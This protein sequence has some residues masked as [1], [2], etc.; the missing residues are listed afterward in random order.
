MKNHEG[1][2]EGAGEEARPWFETYFGSDYLRT[3]RRQLTASTVEEVDFLVDRLGIGKDDRLLDIPCGH[4]RHA[5]ELVRRGYSV[6]GVDLS[7]DLLQ[8]ARKQAASQ[9]LTV[10]F[11]HMDMRELSFD[12]EFGAAYNVFN[13]FGYFGKEE[14]HRVLEGIAQALEPGGRFL[15]EQGNRDYY[16]MYAPQRSW[17]ELRDC[18]VLYDF[19]FNVAS[20]VAHTQQT[21]IDKSTQETRTHDI[22]VRVYSLPELREMLRS[23][24]LL[25]Y[26]VYGDWDES[27]FT[28]DSRYMITCA[29]KDDGTRR[30]GSG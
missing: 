2:A 8:L 10:D 22:R 14:D 9:E 18:Y 20:G 15:L 12:S 17:E 5:L 7:Q 28:S 19:A 1:E 11:L 24:G 21:I 26:S 16:L 4:G 3:H 25:V 6:T 23:V 29:I 13:S 27:S 30:R